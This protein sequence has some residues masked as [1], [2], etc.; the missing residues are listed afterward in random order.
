MINV[1]AIVTTQPGKRAEL[2]HAIHRN[3]LAIRAEDGCIEFGPTID[4][5]GPRDLQVPLG[6]DV[7]VLV[8]KWASVEAL[9]AHLQAPHMIEYFART[10][11]L[12]AH[13]VVHVLSA[14]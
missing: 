7:L 12:V 3:L 14:A 4:A 2:L 8:E 1:I 13:A 11:A 6:D 5:S 9:E 10:Q